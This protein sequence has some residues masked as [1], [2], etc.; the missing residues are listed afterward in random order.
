[1][2]L[3]FEWDGNKATTNS[4]KH[5]VT[6]EE[7]RSAFYDPWRIVNPDDLHSEGEDRW[8]VIGR[9]ARGRLAVVVCTK[10]GDRIRIIGARRTTPRERREYED[11]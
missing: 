5:G 9:T 2:R 7:A 4:A 8:C 3:K 1:V 6:F 11:R 10:R